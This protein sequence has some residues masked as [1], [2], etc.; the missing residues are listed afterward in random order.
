MKEKDYCL[1]GKQEVSSNSKGRRT[2]MNV[3]RTEQVS[4]VNNKRW[5]L[6]LK[7]YESEVYY[8]S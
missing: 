8:S 6:F 7:S 4:H 1:W 5:K 3:L 2:Q